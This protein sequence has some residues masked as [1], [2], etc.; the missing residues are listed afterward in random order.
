MFAETFILLYLG[1][2][3]ADYPLQPDWQAKCKAGWDEGPDDAHPGRHHHGWGANLAHAATH[4]LVCA[5]TLIVGD[6]ALGLDIPDTPAVLALAWIGGSHALID[7]RR[8]VAWWMRHARQTAW[9]QHGGA[10]HVD[11]TAHVLALGMAA[12]ALAA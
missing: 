5:V 12:L 11:Q 9:A 1:H 3:V 2:L 6:L 4:V 10:A 7:R 8:I